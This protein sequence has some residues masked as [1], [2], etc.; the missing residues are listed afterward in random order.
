MHGAA[1]SLRWMF[2][3]TS[4]LLWRT[5]AYGQL[6]LEGDTLDEHQPACSEE[7]WLAGKG[8]ADSKQRVEYRRRSWD[9]CKALGATD[10]ACNVL[11]AIAIRESSGDTCSVHVLGPGEYGLGLHGLSVG[12]HLPK[13][14]SSEEGLDS[15]PLLYMPEVSTVVTMRI[16]RRA[17]GAYGAR[18]WRDVAAVF[19]GRF[20]F[21][22]GEIPVGD[23]FLFCR[24][25]TRI[26]IDCNADPKGKLGTKLG[27]KKEKGQEEFLL[28]LLRDPKHGQ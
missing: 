13:W 9:T 24:R 7:A 12:L 2:A 28:D 23:D 5:L 8:R 3:F 22:P 21:T 17:V 1:G 11:D 4:L 14:D 15:A 25:L 10:E 26:G 19:A 20:T 18:R 16:F 6:V 27:R